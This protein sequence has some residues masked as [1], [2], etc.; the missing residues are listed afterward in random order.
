MT[1]APRTGRGIDGTTPR[2]LSAL[3]LFAAALLAIV[4]AA[5]GA[6]AAKSPSP[7][8]FE[9]PYAGVLK[10]QRF[11]PTLA[12]RR[13]EVNRPLGMPAA[14]RIARGLGLDKADVFTPRQYALFISGKGVG[15]ERAPAELVDKSVRILTNTNGNPLYA[16]VEGKKTPVVVGSYGLM[17]NTEGMLESPAN[18]TAPTRQVN[19]VIEPGGYL[20]TW[21]KNN[22]AEAALRTLYRSAFTAEAAWGNRAQQQSGVAQLVP[23]GFQV[24]GMSMA[25]PL[26]LVNFSLI[27]TLNPKLAAKM[28]ANWTPIPADVALAIAESPTGQ[29]PYSEYRS[30]L[31]M[32]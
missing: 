11:A 32:R 8:G 18:S 1:L 24:V 30:S 15:G 13:G 2:A 29:V 14:D 21:C 5:T 20:S 17:V 12:T 7:S 28:P 23:N 9:E 31:S 26:W 6:V 16:N 27:Y 22:G 10:Y 25:P 3:G 19:S 4:V